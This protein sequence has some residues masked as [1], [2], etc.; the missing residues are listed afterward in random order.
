[1]EGLFQYRIICQQVNIGSLEQVVKEYLELAEKKTEEARQ[2]S[3]QAVL[4][5]QAVDDLDQVATPE[6]LLLSAVSSEGNQERSD[7]V[8]LTPWVKFLWESYRQCLE[9]L[10]NNSRVE[11]LYHDIAQAAFRFCVNY[12]R[13]TEFR[14]LCDNL[15]VHLTH[16]H[17]FQ[18]TATAV[19]L[20][21]VET[22]Q[23]HLETRLTQLDMA[24][25]MELWQEAYKAAEDT[26]A[27]MCLSKKS[28]KP[29]VMDG[30][31]QRL[32]L[33][34]LKAGNGLFHASALQ[35]HLTLVRDLK[36][37]K[38]AEEMRRLASRALLATLACPL[39]A[40]R[41]EMDNLVETDEAVLDKNSRVLANLLGLANP[42]SRQGL[43]RDLQRLGV[44]ALAPPELQKLYALLETDFDP[45]N[46]SSGV[47][48]AFEYIK[49]WCTQLQ[50]A[51]AAQSA[52]SEELPSDKE[53]LQLADSQFMV[54]LKGLKQMMV[55]R[56][57]R[58][59][60]QVYESISI[61]RVL[62]LCPM[63]DAFE[64]EAAVVDAVRR[65]SLQVR[66]DHKRQALHFGSELSI[67]QREESSAEG[68]PKLQ[69]M[70]SDLIRSQLEKLYRV[71]KESVHM[72][73]P[74]NRAAE[75]ARIRSEILKEYMQIHKKEH[76]K[77][78]ER[79]SK[80]EKRKEE[81]ENKS[82]AREEAER[83]EEERRQQR[84][85]EAEEARL[86]KEAQEREE[87]RLAREEAP[88]FHS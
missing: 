43:V 39:P 79:Q 28:I 4:E 48:K 8:L 64:L 75:Q 44:V 67:S 19:N 68:G 35:R 56:L 7:R 58:E 47:S 63:V 59:I 60:A 29:Q 87:L 55:C 33:V 17:R 12:G 81:L 82:L 24:I 16:I 11:R 80:I 23:M 30:Y 15:R 65:H 85:R 13:K 20:Q 40:T 21:S 18:T 66:V 52:G 6:S 77:I 88:G 57:L 53:K 31:Y 38:T 74:E 73:E 9:L 22:Q 26:H 86:A 41:P 69:A 37:S 34:F 5:T 50:E 84:L 70:P 46:L 27:M 49:E 61:E 45:L 51:S 42:P 10:R 36:R 1:M 25:K 32:A 71:L 62:Q 76:R 3:A 83:A 14:K 72:I 2:A 54:Y 78:L